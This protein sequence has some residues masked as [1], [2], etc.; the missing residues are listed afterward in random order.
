LGDGT[1]KNRFRPVLV[2][3]GLQ[4]VQVSAGSYTSCGITSDNLAYCWGSGEHGLLGNGESHQ[5]ERPVPVKGGLHFTQVT[6]ASTHSCALTTD[7]LA[8]CWGMNFA[9]QLG[10]G[11]TSERNVP[12]PVAG[13]LHFRRLKAGG[14]HFQR[15]FYNEV[16]PGTCAL[17]TDNKTYC[18]GGQ[19]HSPTAIPGGFTFQ[20]VTDGCGITAE[21][22]AYC[23]HDYGEPTAFAA[24]LSWSQLVIEDLHSCGITTSNHAYCW[25]DNFTGGLGDGT[26][27]NRADPTP[28]IGGLLFVGVSP[29]ATGNH[30]CALT[31]AGRAYCWGHNAYGQLG[32]GSNIGPETCSGELPCSTKPR[33]VVGP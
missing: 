19:H 25:G 29:G 22:K 10:D 5:R 6:M 7:K 12:V 11:T 8:Y 20:Q 21:H 9:G 17:G 3:R 27:T 18:W 15:D 2:Q 14:D 33:A 13:G 23:W 4:F 28:V 24:G 26:E 1:V 32:G 30:T 31:S 16:V